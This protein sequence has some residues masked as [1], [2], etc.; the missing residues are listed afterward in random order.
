MQ[1]LLQLLPPGQSAL[2]STYESWS[3]KPS[4]PS[5][6][7]AMGAEGEKLGKIKRFTIFYERMNKNKIGWW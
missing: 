7:K 2:Q 1:L 5:K 6:V 4:I 3:L